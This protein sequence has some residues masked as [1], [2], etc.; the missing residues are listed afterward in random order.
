LEWIIELRKVYPGI[1]FFGQDDKAKIPVGDSV[2]VATGVRPGK[3]KGIAPVDEPNPMSAM[4]HDFHLGSMGTAM[5]VEVAKC[6]HD[7][8]PLPLGIG[9]VDEH[10]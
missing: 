2:P 5:E 4:D 7:A 1:E 10:E 6:V 8:F 9:R 3:L